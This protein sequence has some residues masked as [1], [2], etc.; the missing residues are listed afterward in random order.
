ML[1]IHIERSNRSLQLFRISPAPPPFLPTLY[2]KGKGSK[3]CRRTFAAQHDRYCM[4]KANKVEKRLPF[5]STMWPRTASSVSIYSM[6]SVS[7]HFAIC[8]FVIKKAPSAGIYLKMEPNR[9]RTESSLAAVLL[10]VSVRVPLYHGCVL[11]RTR[12][13]LDKPIAFPFH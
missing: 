2:L 3:L 8:I 9:I 13:S 12:L 4:E 5:R 10:H 7:I 11:T 1:D 6:L